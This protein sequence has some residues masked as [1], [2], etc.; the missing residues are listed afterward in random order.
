[1]T[2][3]FCGYPAEPCR[4]GLAQIAQQI[5]EPR[6]RRVERLA[7]R[8]PLELDRPQLVASLLVLADHSGFAAQ[9]GVDR[10]IRAVPD[11]REVGVVRR[12]PSA[13]K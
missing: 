3:L 7:S 12:R 6:H 11:Q 2:A 4:S 5:D 9:R 8:D 13:Q 10:V 1:M